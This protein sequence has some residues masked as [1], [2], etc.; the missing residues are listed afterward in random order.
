MLTNDTGLAM[1]E[2]HASERA[3]VNVAHEG[4]VTVRKRG[5]LCVLVAS[6]LLAGLGT[7]HAA[8]TTTVTPPSWLFLAPGRLF[9]GQG[10]PFLGNTI[11]S[12]PP[13]LRTGVIAAYR[14]SA[15]GDGA[16]ASF[17]VAT[18]PSAAL[19]QK[20]DRLF[21]SRL[22]PSRLEPQCKSLPHQAGQWVRWCRGVVLFS[23]SV[24]NHEATAAAGRVLGNQVIMAQAYTTEANSSHVDPATVQRALA[25][26]RAVVLRDQH[27]MAH[28]HE[29]PLSRLLESVYAQ[30][31]SC[32]RAAQHVLSDVELL[33]AH[34][35]PPISPSR[36]S[37]DAARA[38]RV[39]QSLIDDLHRTEAASKQVTSAPKA[40]R[41]GSVLGASLKLAA[42][43]SGGAQI[44]QEDLGDPSSHHAHSLSD[45]V[46]AVKEGLSQQQSVSIDVAQLIPRYL[47]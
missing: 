15:R 28:H 33:Q 42:A 2:A 11:A 14:V 6:V 45:G 26:E 46:A 7:T 18:F 27:Y 17:L 43:C 29:T 4:V 36:V 37:Q 5:I 19:A 21:R 13:D 31:G 25:L 30:L 39:C 22:L 24:W 10:P 20:Y 47:R 35:L 8:A 44:I 16:P 38:H 34:V 40:R 12:T 23:E 32:T 1:E 41:L 3:S 9:L